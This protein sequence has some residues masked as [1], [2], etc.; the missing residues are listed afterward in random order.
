MVKDSIMGDLESPDAILDRTIALTLQ[1]ILNGRPLF[2]SPMGE[3]YFYQRHFR[4][5]VKE[6]LEEFRQSTKIEDTNVRS[7]QEAQSVS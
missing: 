5:W 2:P 7:L 4:S 6:G 3:P 1:E